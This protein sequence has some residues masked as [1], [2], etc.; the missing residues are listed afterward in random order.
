[1][2]SD[3][4]WI[5]V[6]GMSRSGTTLLTSMLDAHPGISMGYELLPAGLPALA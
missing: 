3:V 6:C 4:R 2:N 5:H 1:M